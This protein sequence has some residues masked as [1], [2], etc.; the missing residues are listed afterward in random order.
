[1]CLFF[2]FVFF[3]CPVRK[4]LPTSREI[5]VLKKCVF[6]K[7]TGGETRPPSFPLEDLE[8]AELLKMRMVPR[9]KWTLAMQISTEP[10]P[11]NK[12]LAQNRTEA[13]PSG[14]R[15]APS[16]SVFRLQTSQPPLTMKL[17][18]PCLQGI[19]VVN[20]MPNEKNPTGDTDTPTPSVKNGAEILN[21]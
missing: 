13:N 3:F 18:P 16:T 21:F 11:V 14:L 4:S 7:P 17:T 9:R 5:S 1:M 15:L 12:Q 20:D 19:K 6:S 8:D 10:K 2:V